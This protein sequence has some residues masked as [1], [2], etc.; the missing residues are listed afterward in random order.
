M[1][2][3]TE[4]KALAKERISAWKEAG[5]ITQQLVEVT[6]DLLDY[7]PENINFCVFCEKDMKF[8]LALRDHLR[9][10]HPE[11]FKRRNNLELADRERMKNISI[12]CSLVPKPVSPGEW[13]IYEAIVWELTAKGVS[14]HKPHTRPSSKELGRQAPSAG[15]VT[16]A[17]QLPCSDQPSTSS[18][19]QEAAIAS[20]NGGTRRRRKS[21]RHSKTPPLE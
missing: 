7:L 20:T 16:P 1:S 9:A 18:A 11:E 8:P 2:T 14:I 3:L 13:R 12:D 5:L 17:G 6:E 21:G 19:Q 4:R 10:V 15:C